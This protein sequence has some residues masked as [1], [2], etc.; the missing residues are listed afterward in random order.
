M[1]V[2]LKF[3]TRSTGLV[4]SNPETPIEPPAGTQVAAG[5]GLAAAIAAASNGATLLLRGGTHTIGSGLS[6]SPAANYAGIITSRYMTIKNYPGETPVV[7]WAADVR[8]NGFYFTGSAGPIL[9]QGISFLA[10]STVTNDANGCAMIE[11]DGCDDLTIDACTF[12]G[13]AS[14]DDHQQLVYQRLG[15]NI[16]VTDSTFSANGSDG[17]GF[18]QYPE[19]TGGDPVTLVSGCLFED[20]AVSGGVTSDS[21]ITV[22]GCTFNDNNI[23]VQLRNGADNSVITNNDGTGNTTELQL[24]GCTGVTDSGNTWT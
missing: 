20:F 12:T 5:T 2:G 21:V 24:N 3:R 8:N 10:T 22:D 7:T 17:F 15:T 4:L 11:S 16:T 9:V 19:D 13:N 1:P 6:G 14:W 23:A 18:H